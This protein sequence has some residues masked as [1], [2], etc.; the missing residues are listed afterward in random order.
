MK[1]AEVAVNAPV[2]GPRTFTYSLPPNHSVS[3]GCAVWV[4]FG[5]RILQGV[6]FNLTDQSPVENTK[7][8]ID[9][10]DSRPLLSEAQVELAK[11][12]AEYYRAPYFETAN[13]MLPPAFERKTLTFVELALDAPPKAPDNLTPNQKKMFNFL[14]KSGRSDSR[15]FKK[16]IAEKQILP[17]IKQLEK[18]GLV[19]KTSELQ[20]ERVKPREVLYVRLAIDADAANQKIALLEKKA[21]RQAELLKLLVDEGDALPLAEAAK[22]T[23]RT[24][25]AAHALQKKGLVRIE[26]IEVRRD[27]LG[28][29]TF[30]PSIPTKLTS[31]QQSAWEQI[32]DGLH[33]GSHTFLLHGITGSGKTEIYLRALQ[34]TIAQGRKGF[35]LVPEIALT[36]QTIERFASRFPNRVAVLHSKLSPGEQFDEWHR[37]REGEFDVVIGSRGAIFAPQPDL[38][39]IVIDEEH[40]WTYKQHEK[41]P[42]YHARDVAL[43]LAELTGAVVVLGSATPDMGSYHRAQDLL[44]PC[45]GLRLSICAGNLRQ[46][47]GASSAGVWRG[48]LMGLWMP[49]SR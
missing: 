44:L 24:P 4:P 2:A 6:V 47:I 46:V 35:V 28:H 37:I 3:P 26:K 25:A 40:E 30:Q 7:E 29:R 38:G 12:I 19:R 48:P 8:I 1:Y 36:P 20:H 10:I 42:L 45:R 18:K 31:A 39:L 41:T 13:L 9:V 43:K 15:Q 34:E 21:F 23:G 33:A 14:L 17:T 5:P 11:W 49:A 22:R 32:R 27:P 16:R